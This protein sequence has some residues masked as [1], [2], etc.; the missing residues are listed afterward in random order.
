LLTSQPTNTAVDCYS[1]SPIDKATMLDAMRLKFGL[2]YQLTDGG[3]S[4]VN[5]TGEKAHYYSKNRRAADFG[6][7]PKLTSLEGIMLEAEALIK[8]ASA[9]HIK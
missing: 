1:K 8:G 5:A 2:E 6:Y 9:L 3:T 7:V 4:G